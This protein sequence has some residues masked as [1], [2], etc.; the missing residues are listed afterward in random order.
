MTLADLARAAEMQPGN[1]RRMLMSTTTSPRLGSVMRLLPPLHCQVG[2]GGSRTADELVALL[3]TERQRQ[4]RTWEQLLAPI[5]LDIRKTSASLSRPD[6]L[7]LDVVTRLAEALH[8]DLELVDDPTSSPPGKRP[9]RRST[10]QEAGPTASGPRPAAA[11]AVPVRSAPE[12]EAGTTSAPRSTSTAAANRRAPDDGVS[13]LPPASPLQGASARPRSGLSLPPLRPPRLGRYQ[14]APPAAVPSHSPSTWT[15]PVPSYALEVAILARLAEV[16]SED[17]SDGFTVA[18]QTFASGLS[19]PVRFIEKLG[20]TTFDALQR[21]RRK[22][23]D[24]I[25]PDLTPPPG[26]FDALDA[27]P[28]LRVWQA[29]RQPGYR[30]PDIWFNYDHLGVVAHSVALDGETVVQLRLAPQGSPHRLTAIVHLPQGGPAT[31][32]MDSE[33]AMTIKIGGEPHHFT[34]ICAGPVF[35]ELVVGART[36]LVA[37]ISSLLAVVEVHADTAR[38]I[39][40]GRAAALPALNIEPPMPESDLPAAAGL[41][42]PVERPEHPDA[43]ARARALTAEL[44]ADKNQE[45]QEALEQRQAAEERAAKAEAVRDTGVAEQAVLE[46]LGHVNELLAV[47]TQRANDAGQLAT[48]LAARL[49]ALE[50]ELVAAGH[51]EA[52]RDA[53]EHERARLAE[54]LLAV[55]SELAELRKAQADDAAHFTSL[56]AENRI[57]EAITFFARRVLGA[58]VD[59]ADQAFDALERQSGPEQQEP[60]T[61]ALPSPPLTVSQP[62]SPTQTKIG[63][64]EPCPCGSGK[65][66]KRCCSIKAVTPA[67][68]GALT[69]SSTSITSGGG[70]TRGSQLPVGR[71]GVG[72]DPPASA[73]SGPAEPLAP[74]IEPEPEVNTAEHDWLVS[75]R[76]SRYLERLRKDGPRRTTLASV[77]IEESASRWLGKK[78]RGPS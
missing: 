56:L 14:T 19:L 60:A 28:L 77:P 33:V 61:L 2:P 64:N 39:W 12:H 78:S 37:A 23:E 16:T 11:P 74:A 53:A 36:Y 29:S 73:A 31:M 17:W 26:C 18:V 45:C 8:I 40:G 59:D 4:E 47:E 5:G 54:Q 50:A 49:E 25:P 67:E 51:V 65:K 35:G 44:D 55:G 32:H 46:E 66:Y 10:A 9:G 30:P 41:A 3:D 71:H 42:H 13:P 7:S 75:K 57:P 76:T 63:R 15:P 62:A 1:L 70:S 43:D 20:R 69:T 38:V 34:H 24:G 21:F 27:T 58:P 68:E 72:A 6:R 48:A 22:P 52:Q